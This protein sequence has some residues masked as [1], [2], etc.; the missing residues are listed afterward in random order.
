[1]QFTSEDSVIQGPGLIERANGCVEIGV[2]KDDQ[3]DGM[4]TLRFSDGHME[5]ILFINGRPAK[6]SQ[7]SDN[8][9]QPT[10]D[11]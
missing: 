10:H 9:Y 6:N 5:S 4:W 11:K 2:Y 8:H 3:Q 7:M 1:M